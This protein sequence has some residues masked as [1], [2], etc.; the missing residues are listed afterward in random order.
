M[1]R[2]RRAVNVGG[3]GVIA[4]YAPVKIKTGRLSVESGQF[5]RWEE[6]E[7]VREEGERD[8]EEETHGRWKRRR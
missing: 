3:E 5:M 8:S 6:G 4:R 2:D 1:K 7:R